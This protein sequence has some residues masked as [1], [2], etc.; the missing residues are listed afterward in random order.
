[1]A[2]FDEGTPDSLSRAITLLADNIGTVPN[3]E[4][5]SL[6]SAALISA[7]EAYLAE[8]LARAAFRASP[9]HKFAGVNALRAAKALGARDRAME[10][11]PLVVS[12]SKV[13]T[14]GRRQLVQIADWLGLPP[15]D[16]AAP[17]SAPAGGAPTK[18]H[19]GP[20]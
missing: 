19:G 5:V 3:V 2:A 6:L 13:G 12:Q 18:D 10:L 17:S 9:S 20:S 16:G 8:P 7:D 15:P 1:V 11:Y 4:A 14:W